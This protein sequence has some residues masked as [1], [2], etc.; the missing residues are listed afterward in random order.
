[1]TFRLLPLA[2]LV[3]LAPAASGQPLRCGDEIEPGRRIE[4]APTAGIAAANVGLMA[5]LALVRA[6]VDGR[7]RAWS[8]VAEVAGAGAAA[9]L[10]FA[11]AKHEVGA[12]R[13]LPGVAL[14]YASASALE[15]VVEDDHPLAYARVGVA[16]ADVRLRTSFARRPGPEVAV[17]LDPVGL[18]GL[19]VLPASGYRPS[20][21]GGAL[22]YRAPAGLGVGTEPGLTAAGATLGRLVVLE[23]E[24]DDLVRRHEVVHAL[25][26]QQLG[27]AAPYGTLGRI[28]PRLRWTSGGGRVRWDVR[29]GAA[30]V[31]LSLAEGLLLDYEDRPT[32]VEA[33]SL[34][35][36]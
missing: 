8:D 15:N 31:V 35:D 28:A 1:M 5:G 32:E 12:G 2:L 24:A 23:D 29:S 21:A 16:F 6:A 27:A 30:P 10:G 33:F 18:V 20:L 7:L 13:V 25:Q 4:C 22:T 36:R 3:A 9:G 19:A 34:A 11:L 17:E 14:G 26:S